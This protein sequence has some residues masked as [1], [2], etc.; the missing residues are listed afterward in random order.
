MG[1][2][3]ISAEEMTGGAYRLLCYLY[4]RA[5]N[6]V[7]WEELYFRGYRGLDHVPRAPDDEGYEPPALYERTLYSRMSDL[8]KAIEP[9]PQH[10]LY[11]DAVKGKGVALRLSW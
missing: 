8:R 7:S 3:E 6:I 5:G 10:P 4:K 11:L 9:D 1:G 2:R